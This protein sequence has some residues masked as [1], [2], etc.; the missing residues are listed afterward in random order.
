M[1]NLSIPIVLIA[2]TLVASCGAS[3][4][5]QS[6][7][8]NA[9]TQSGK[10]HQL[11]DADTIKV[12][13]IQKSED[14]WKQILTAEEYHILRERGTEPAF[15]NEYYDNKKEG[16]YYCAACGLPIYSSKTK[17]HSGTGWP[18]FWAPIDPKLVKTKTD[19]RLGMER[20][21]VLCARCG[22]H[23]GHI[24]QWDT[25]SGLRHCVNSVAFDF[26]AQEL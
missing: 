8:N 19:T 20:T 5:D 6:Q 17:F 14:E 13:T 24:F 15:Q 26:K 25:V 12:N 4:D 21:E 10:I 1:K 11:A 22:S 23:L 18:S 3:K 2:L 9:N 7:A 16:I